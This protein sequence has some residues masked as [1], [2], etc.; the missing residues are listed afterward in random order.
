M[1]LYARIK[2][3][4]YVLPKNLLDNARLAMEYPDWDVDKILNKTGINE[5]YVVDPGQTACDLAVLACEKI[6]SSSVSKESIDAIIFCTQ[7]PDY[8]LP[9]TACIL[10]NR[11]GISTNCMAFDINQ[12]C[13]GY[14]Y[15]LGIAKGLIETGQATNALVVT[16]ETYSHYIH[17][18][19]RSVRTLFGDA[20]AVTW[21]A[22]ETEGRGLERFRYGTDG[23][24]AHNLIVPMGRARS[25]IS[26]ISKIPE[27]SDDKGNMRSAAHLYMN[28][29]AIFEFSMTRV[30][31]IYKSLFDEE[32]TE[33][34]LDRVVFH[35]ANSFML[36][37]LRRRLRI[38]KEKFVSKFSHCGNTVSS[39]IPI[40]LKESLEDGSVREGTALAL[41]GFGVG[42]SWAACVA[43]I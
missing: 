23:S 36:D 25:P 34:H 21:V 43:H 15:G 29:P 39:S 42:Y 11:V 6:F 33:E 30:P 38:P 14:I 16:A 10:Q 28:G 31:Q 32:F 4:E 41:V 40:A 19:D 3:I 37:A 26:D 18:G 22:G 17:P 12:G 27:I 2:A 13:S 9:A 35:Q 20:A 5:R 24:G 8:S 1:T 7:S